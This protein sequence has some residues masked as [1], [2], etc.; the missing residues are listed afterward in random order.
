MSRTRRRIGSRWLIALVLGC[1]PWALLAAVL[2]LPWPRQLGVIDGLPTTGIHAMAEDATG[3]LWMAS[4]EGLLRFDGRRS[5]VWGDEHGLHD[6]TLR[7]LHVDAADRVWVGTVS[8]GLL[9]LGGDRRRFERAGTQ[10]PWA[11]RSGTIHAIAG[12][13]GSTLWVIG[14]DHRLYML[15]ALD[16]RWQVV[17]AAAD[18]VT[19]LAIDHAGRLWVGTSQGLRRFADGRLQRAGTP[20]VPT[21]RYRPC[22]PIPRAASMPATG[23]A[24]GGKPRAGRPAPR[25]G[26]GDRC[27]AVPMAPCG[28]SAT[29]ACT[30]RAERTPSAFPPAV[31]GAVNARG[32]DGR[33]GAG[34]ARRHLVPEQDAWRVAAAGAVA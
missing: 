20:R 15:P 10:M 19:A 28:R 33:G 13:G 29:R 14:S 11:V 32:G 5:R 34:P 31:A 9:M 16:A 4:S 17:D 23:C 6:T 24:R 30:C 12:G 18:T 21:V 7:A 25:R 27:C 22:G 1:W 26:P 3:Y 2:D 8:Q